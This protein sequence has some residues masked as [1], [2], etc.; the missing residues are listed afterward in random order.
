MTREHFPICGG[1]A[2]NTH[3]DSAAP[4]ESP[5]GLREGSVNVG[6]REV[7]EGTEA[8]RVRG[9]RC[10]GDVVDGGCECD[11]IGPPEPVAE[12]YAG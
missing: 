5:F 1:F 11:V 12:A 6:K 3:A 8:P 4:Q 9:D 7:C 10:V 2:G